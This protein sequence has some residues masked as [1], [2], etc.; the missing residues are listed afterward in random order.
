MPLRQLLLIT[1]LPLTT[2]AYAQQAAMEGP[3]FRSVPVDV[4]AI[5]ADGKVTFSLEA[6]EAREV[7][8]VNTTGGWTEFPEGNELAMQKG[9]DGVWTLTIGPVP[10]EFYTYVFMVDGVRVLDPGNPLVTR[11]GRN[12]SSRLEIDGASTANYRHR[13]VPHGTVAHVWAPWPSLGISKRMTVYTPP[14]YETGNERYPVLYL[15]HGGGGDEDAWAEIGRAPEIL[16]NLIASGRA[17]PMIVVMTNIYYDQEAA[18]N[19]IP[20]IPPPGNAEDALQ[21]PPALVA[22]LVPFIDATYRTKADAADRA[23]AGL[24]RG[25]MMTFI[26]AFNHIDAFQWVGSLA[27]G[28]PLLPGASVDIPPPPNA[29]MLRGPDVTKT[30]DPEKVLQL[31]PQLNAGANDSLQLLYVSVGAQDGL[32]TANREMR[33]IIESQGVAAEYIEV[34]GYGHE[35]AYWRVALQDFLPRLFHT[36]SM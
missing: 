11:D 22:D 20:V 25:G 17:R 23:I 4:P 8:L 14:G 6:P 24:S 27:G 32:I 16:D 3:E 21:Y 26:A 34:P 1:V 7:V 31:M 33:R 10:A 18:R 36:D 2:A 5:H 19:Y 13:E 30:I 28:F 15:H 9:S 35:W 29:N 12:Y